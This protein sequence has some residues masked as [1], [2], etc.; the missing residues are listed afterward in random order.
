ME[1]L[2]ILLYIVGI[3]LLVILCI[4]GIKLIIA[5]DK[6]S[7]LADNITEKVDSFNGALNIMNKACNGIAS[8]SDSFVFGISNLVSKVLK[9]LKKKENDSDEM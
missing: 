1:I 2:T 9:Y 7:S 3:V 6:F 4:L 8:V 5:V